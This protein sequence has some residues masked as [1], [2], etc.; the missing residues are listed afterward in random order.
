[1]NGFTELAIAVVTS[2]ACGSFLTLLT[3]W[4]SGLFDGRGTWERE[5]D[6]YTAGMQEA[7]SLQCES[8]AEAEYTEHS[9]QIGA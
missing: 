3:C 4:A 7:L 8:E 5:V 2:M 6:A 9:A 1:M